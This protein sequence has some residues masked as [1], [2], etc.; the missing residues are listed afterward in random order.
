MA[1]KKYIYNK[2]GESRRYIGVN[3]ADQTFYEI[4]TNRL[5]KFYQN[6]LI[7]AQ[8]VADEIALSLDGVSPLNNADSLELFDTF[9][10]AHT[11]FYEQNLAFYGTDVKTVKAAL[12]K[13]ENQFIGSSKAGLFEATK[14]SS[15]N[16]TSIVT[17]C[18]FNNEKKNTDTG[19]Y[20]L[21]TTT[22]EVTFNR[23]AEILANSNI[24]SN[25]NSNSRTSVITYMEIDTGSGYTKQDGSEGYSYHRQTSNGHGTATSQSTATVNAGDKLRVQMQRII[26]DTSFPLLPNGCSLVITE[27]SARGP[28]GE[29]GSAGFEYRYGSGVPANGL[30][31]DSDVYTDTITGDQYKKESGTWNFKLNV[32]GP[33]GNVDRMLLWAEENGALSNNNTQWSFGNGSVGNIGVTMIQGGSLIGMSFNGETAPTSTCTVEVLINGASSG[34]SIT[35]AATVNDEHVIFGSPVSFNA[36]DRIGFRTVLGGSAS[37][38]RVA[39]LIEN[40]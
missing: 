9:A 33:S 35:V 12:D 4:P 5:I 23:T 29:M 31:F 3:V 17:T 39:V 27:A 28:Q 8:L 34:E 30:G 15:Q 16:I 37:D 7:R 20:T 25:V 26:G 1:I 21:N 22:G 10:F 19:L 38:C 14:S 2:S 6:D 32:K 11:T 13:I 18:I 40:S 24:S 36:G